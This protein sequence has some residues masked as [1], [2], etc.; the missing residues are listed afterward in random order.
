M[1]KVVGDLKL[2]SVVELSEKLDIQPGTIR[3][4]L[5]S[6]KLKGRKLAKKWYMAEDSLAEYFQESENK[7]EEV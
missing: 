1:P 5:K 3:K 4:L 7:P 6:G 2:Y